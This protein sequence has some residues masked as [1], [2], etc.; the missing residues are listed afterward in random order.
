[1]VE[2]KEDIKDTRLST[3]LNGY[4]SLF[5]SV[6]LPIAGLNFKPPLQRAYLF[7][8]GYAML[9]ESECLY[10]Q[11]DCCL[12]VEKIPAQPVQLRNH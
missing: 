1:M 2:H 8:S 7:T 10:E 6:R 11:K 12:H 9:V 5:T 3:A 4:F